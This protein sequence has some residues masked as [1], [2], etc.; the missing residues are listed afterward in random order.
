MSPSL[1]EVRALTRSLG[2]ERGLSD[3]SLTACVTGSLP[4][5]H[6]SHD[7]IPDRMQ[8][9]GCPVS[10]LG[11]HHFHWYCKTSFRARVR[12]E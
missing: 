1:N 9:Q 2:L 5:R 6:I 3:V 8:A 11:R 4:P 7:A 10:F 12:V